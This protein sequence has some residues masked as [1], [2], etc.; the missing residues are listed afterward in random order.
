MDEK[1]VSC[2]EP[3]L[4]ISRCHQATAL[5]DPDSFPLFMP[6][7]GNIHYSKII[8]IAGDGKSECSMLNQFPTALVHGGIAFCK[9]HICL[10]NDGFVLENRRFRPNNFCIMLI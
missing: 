6:V 10:L 3:G 7:P 9:S 4:L 1:T 5:C 8:L 2:E